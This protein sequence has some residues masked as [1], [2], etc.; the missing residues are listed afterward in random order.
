MNAIAL[1]TLA[2]AINTWTPPHIPATIPHGDMPGD[3][4]QIGPEHIAKANTIF[5]A[6]VPMAAELA[7]SGRVVITVCGGSGVGKSEIASLL[8]HY[9]RTAGVGSYTLSGDNYPK[10]IPMYNDA[11]RN[12]IFRAA[13]LRGLVEAGTYDKAVKETLSALWLQETDAE[14][15]L[16]EQYPWLKIYQDRGRKALAGYLGTEA[17]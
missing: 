16:T 14:P 11:E 1:Q 2:A 4:V 12:R 10:R 9:F 5:P 3:K 8:S 15:T 7:Q 6:L 13:G 17:E